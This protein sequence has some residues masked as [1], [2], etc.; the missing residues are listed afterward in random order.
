VCCRINSRVDVARYRLFVLKVPLN[1]GSSGM[2][3]VRFFVP[4]TRHWRKWAVDN[5]TCLKVPM[6]ITELQCHLP[7]SVYLNKRTVGN[8]AN[9]S[10]IYGISTIVSV[11]C[12]MSHRESSE[13][14]R[15]D[16]VR[17]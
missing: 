17:G 5:A 8:S 4:K 3:D 12:P 15:L 6:W 13:G 10:L 7:K 14:G 2:A 16:L 9:L 11:I 1:T